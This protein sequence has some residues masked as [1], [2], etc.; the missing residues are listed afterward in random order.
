MDVTSEGIFTPTVPS[1]PNE[2]AVRTPSVIF[3]AKAAYPIVLIENPSSTT[4]LV[5]FLLL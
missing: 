4:T 5:R 1:G 3:F 2:G